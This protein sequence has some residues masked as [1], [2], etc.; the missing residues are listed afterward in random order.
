MKKIMAIMLMAKMAMAQDEHSQ[1]RPARLAAV[2]PEIVLTEKPANLE[3]VKDALKDFAVL[4]DTEA[5]DAIAM[6]NIKRDVLENDKKEAFALVVYSF[7]KAYGTFEEPKES[8]QDSDVMLFRDHLI[9]GG[10]TNKEVKV[11]R[12]KGNLLDYLPTLNYKQKEEPKP[13]EPIKEDAK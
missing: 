13:E 9:A 10:I 2:I 8:V 4:P 7:G 11:I 6:D 3:V 1:H 12:Y 5:G